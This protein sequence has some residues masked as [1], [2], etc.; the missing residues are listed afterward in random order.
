MRE[1]GPRRQEEKRQEPPT[2]WHLILPALEVPITGQEVVAPK[3]HLGTPMLFPPV[4]AKAKCGHHRP[5]MP[6]P[7]TQRGPSP[8]PGFTSGS[9]LLT[10]FL[11]G[12]GPHL[13]DHGSQKRWDLPPGPYLDCSLPSQVPSC[14]DPSGLWGWRQICWGWKLLQPI[15]SLLCA[16]PVWHPPS[17][18]RPRHP[19]SEAKECC[20]LSTTCP[21]PQ[22]YNCA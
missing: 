15:P 19:H 18:C 2:A 12:I 20:P 17:S 3:G 1:R 11:P 13:L 7:W 21:M 14:V 10:S 16:R 22:S 6:C 8:D 5:L 4:V 9:A